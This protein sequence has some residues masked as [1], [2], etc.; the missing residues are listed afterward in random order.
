MRLQFVSLCLIAICPPPA[1]LGNGYLNFVSGTTGGSTATYACNDGYMMVGSSESICLED[2]KWS[3]L[4]TC[5]GKLS[6]A[7]HAVVTLSQR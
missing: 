5:Q 6:A 2:R 7:A 4:P 3:T 1:N